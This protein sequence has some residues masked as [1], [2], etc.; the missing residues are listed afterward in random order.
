MPATLAEYA[1]ERQAFLENIAAGLQADGRF[2]AAWLLGSLGR[3]EED[4]VSDIDLAVVVGLPYQ[5]AL[6]A[7]P[8]LTGPQAPPE[9]LG[10]V[11]RFGEPAVIYENHNNA[12]PGGTLT[13]VVYANG[14]VVDWVLIPQETAVRPV[15]VR[16]LF[17]QVGIPVE[18]LPVETTAQRTAG[19]SDRV[20]FFWMMAAVACKYL[21]RGDGPA[22]YSVLQMLD[23]LVVE[24]R[25]MLQ[26]QDAPWQRAPRQALAVDRSGQEAS[27]RD[28]CK[29]MLE[30]MPLL[31]MP[32]GQVPEQEMNVIDLLLRLRK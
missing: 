21:L 19:A 1:A 15:R 26:G 11:S 13:S 20:A 3:G 2:L 5:D 8:W 30:Q 12:R 23:R 10:L 31:T 25:R 28:A 4:E 27:L 7:R 24:V 6:C 18:D 14:L 29:Q 22:F 16:L 32:G 17:D 9:R